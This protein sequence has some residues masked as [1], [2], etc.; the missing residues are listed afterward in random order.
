MQSLLRLVRTLRCLRREQI[1]GQFRES[2]RH[3]LGNPVRFAA[4]H[5]AP[6]LP[7]WR[8]MELRGLPAPAPLHNNAGDLLDGTFSFINETHDIGWPP[9]WATGDGS[10]LWQFNLH[11]FDWLWAL[12]YEAARDAVRDWIDNH[13][14]ARGRVGW[15]SY[16]VS[17]RLMNWT[18]LFQGPFHDHLLEDRDFLGELWQS[19]YLQA[20]WLAAHPET[21][22]QANH[23]LENAAALTFVGSR[24]RTPCGDAWLETGLD[25]LKQELSEQL[26]ADGMHYERSPMYHQRALYLLLLLHAAGPGE[27][28]DVVEPYVPRAAR[29]LELLRHPDGE[30]ALLNDAALGIY[31]H[32]EALLAGY[33]A[34]GLPALPPPA[35]GPWD[36]PDAGYYGWRDAGGNY[37]VCDAG[38]IGPDY[39][40][41]HA[42]GD[43]LSF[44]LSLNGH[45]VIVDSGVHDYLAGDMRR[46][47]R[48]TRAHNTVEIDGADQCEFWADFRVAQRG[49]PFDVEW[50]TGEGGFLLQASHD[51]YA[52][53]PGSP[54]HKRRFVWDRSGGL[55]VTDEILSPAPHTTI[56]RLHLHPA[57]EL[58][59]LEGTRATIRYPGGTLRAAFKGGGALMREESLYCPEFG[60]RLDNTCL[61]FVSSG[62]AVETGFTLEW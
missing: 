39:Q 28:R 4:R 3:R 16:P 52:R 25:L 40:P 30:I 45:R 10:L 31:A 12:E 48:S 42:H 20:E 35:E 9:D 18:A 33:G 60:K 29:A 55:R 19:V 50:R 17:L 34:S 51:G 15:F 21:H 11:Y 8:P 36:L 44:E 54:I 7:A 38:A 22:I 43:M 32:P 49:H 14:L 46:Y 61:A 1:V 26:L 59:E 53:L 41:G 24:F 13:T 56:S 6:D 37:L 58:E 27:V 47:C 62:G 5:P 23:L 2:V 57:C